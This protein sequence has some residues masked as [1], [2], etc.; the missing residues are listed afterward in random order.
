MVLSL[1]VNVKVVVVVG[2]V[3]SSAALGASGEAVV[4][5][6]GASTHGRAEAVGVSTGPLRVA[7][8]HAV[9]TVVA[10]VALT[11]L[12]SHLVTDEATLEACLL[13]FGAVFLGVSSAT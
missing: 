9:E 7:I 4:R 2:V 1:P 3:L 5:G 8:G 6:D 13:A 11:C 10:F 12:V